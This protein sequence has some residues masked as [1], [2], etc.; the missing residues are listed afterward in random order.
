MRNFGRRIQ[1]GGGGGFLL[2]CDEASFRKALSHVRKSAGALLRRD[3]AATTAVRTTARARRDPALLP[4]TGAA[5]YGCTRS[6]RSESAR[7]RHADSQIPILLLDLYPRS[8]PLRNRLWKAS[9]ENQRENTTRTRS[10]IEFPGGGSNCE[11]RRYAI[12]RRYIVGNSRC[13]HRKQALRAPS[14]HRASRP[15]SRKT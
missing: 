9:S 1:A 14:C 15:S 4:S 6:P 2:C 10:P 8:S 3:S 7:H 5:G 13:V 11:T 12:L